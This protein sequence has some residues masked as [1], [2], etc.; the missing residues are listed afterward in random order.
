MTGRKKIH[1]IINLVM[2]YRERMRI[3]VVQEAMSGMKSRKYGYGLQLLYCESFLN[4][5][6]RDDENAIKGLDK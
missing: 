4:E 2:G 1:Y 6:S 5:V 3:L